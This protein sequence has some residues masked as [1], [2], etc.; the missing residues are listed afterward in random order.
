MMN[1]Y[2]Y[3]ISSK[4]SGFDRTQ[5]DIK[6]SILKTS[7]LANVLV[8]TAS[9]SRWLPNGQDSLEKFLQRI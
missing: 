4:M 3:S 2:V 7:N 6:G 8:F 5:T 1:A 9:K